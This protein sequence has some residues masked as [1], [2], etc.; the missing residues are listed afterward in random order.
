MIL[1]NKSMMKHLFHGSYFLN[2]LKFIKRNKRP[3]IK[4]LIQIGK[5]KIKP[6]YNSLV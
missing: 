2:I 3:Y 4:I 5:N 1:E 6:S